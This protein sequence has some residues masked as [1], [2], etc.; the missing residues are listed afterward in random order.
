ME[1]TTYRN[2]K[3]Q[4]AKDLSD[5]RIQ[6]LLIKH[7]CNRNAVANEIGVNRKTVY[8]IIKDNPTL[9]AIIDAE[10]TW[11]RA[12]YERHATKR[13]WSVRNNN[14]KSRAYGMVGTY[15]EQIFTAQCMEMGL[16]PHPTIGD[17][18]PHDLVVM[19]QTNKLYRVQIKGTN[20]PKQGGSYRIRTTTDT[21]KNYDHIN[22]RRYIPLGKEHADIAAC[23]IEQIGT[24]YLVPTSA[25]TSAS[26]TFFP[27]N[28]N[29]CAKYEKY[30]NNWNI[31]S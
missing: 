14:V 25:I 8:R 6:S 7:K 26:M 28:P 17:Y 10:D 24:W 12:L 30:L 1:H 22:R 20:T 5:K 3:G 16:H 29:S 23:Y 18:L 27:T 9:Q 19:S 11:E 13:N 4:F 15:Y 21:P 2:R 31:F